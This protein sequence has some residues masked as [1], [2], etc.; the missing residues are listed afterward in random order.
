MQGSKQAKYEQKKSEDKNVYTRELLYY[1]N[2]M[3]SNKILIQKQSR[4]NKS[5]KYDTLYRHCNCEVTRNNYREHRFTTKI[6]EA[7]ALSLKI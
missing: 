5:Q 1:R 4:V 7:A 3:R 2:I 6:T